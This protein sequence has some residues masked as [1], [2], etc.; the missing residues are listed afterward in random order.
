MASIAPQ[1]RDARR[2]VGIYR[3][4]SQEAEQSTNNPFE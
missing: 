1:V 3:R 2:R 4:P